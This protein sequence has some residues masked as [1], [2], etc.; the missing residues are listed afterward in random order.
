M[1]SCFQ[2]EQKNDL[3]KNIQD[4][5]YHKKQGGGK[6]TQK[7]YLLLLNANFSYMLSDGQD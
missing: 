3:A 4:D 2:N 1:L 7:M 5:K 6:I